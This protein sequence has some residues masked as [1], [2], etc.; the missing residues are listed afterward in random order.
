MLTQKEKETLVIELYKQGANRREIAKK[1]H[2]SF[3]PISD[4]IKRFEG[5][6]SKEK[7]PLSKETKALKLFSKGKDLVYV[8]TKLDMKPEDVKRLYLEYLNLKGLG[9]LTQFYYEQGDQFLPFV[10]FYNNLRS[11]GISTL[12]VI[13]LAEMVDKIP[14]VESN[15]KEKSDSI[16][17]MLQQAQSIAK[18]ISRLQNI[19]DTLQKNISWLDSISNDKQQEIQYLSNEIE[20]VKK[21]YEEMMGVGEYQIPS[22]LSS[23][24]VEWLSNRTGIDANRWQ[25][26]YQ[27]GLRIV[28]S[29]REQ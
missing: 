5:V 9:D 2:M 24:S 10:Q 6:E 16:Q 25:K 29:M 18:E 17:G 1:V 19:E 23:Q 15:F 26:M 11:K 8:A 14:Y 20:K 27:D 3:S 28:L 4:I 21:Q 22:E 7:N 13:E 12:K